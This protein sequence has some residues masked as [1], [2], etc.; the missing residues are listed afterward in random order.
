MAI[1]S[2]DGGRHLTVVGPGAGLRRAL[3]LVLPADQIG[4]EDHLL[5]WNSAAGQYEPNA[6][7]TVNDLQF[8]VQPIVADIT[9]D[10]L[11]E[12]ITTTAVSDLVAAGLT[13]TS[14]TAIRYHTG[15]WGVTAA[16]VGDAPLGARDDGR[17]YV[18]AVTR[19]GWLRLWP[20]NVRADSAA[21]CTSLEE[22]PEYG[23]D[24]FNS[25]NY[26]TDAERPYP[27]RNLSAAV[28]PT[29]D[30]TLALTATGDDR[31]CGT[32]DRYAVRRVAGATASPAW[33]NGQAVDVEAS[34]A[35]AGQ[36][37]TVTVPG[38]PSGTWTLMVRAYDDAGNGSAVRSVVVTIP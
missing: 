9:G 34:P 26:L 10:G 13:H 25:G 7:I 18:A 19:E 36:P 24:A 30:V 37:D 1:G 4:T 12:A 6:P 31:A 8:F 29:G 17:M 32:A 3:D 27:L 23:H 5:L 16:A 20:A 22:W 35:A 2:L 15:G 38:I 33:Q 14:A 21:A 28:G 11:A